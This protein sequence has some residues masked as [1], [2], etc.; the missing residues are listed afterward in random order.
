MSRLIKGSDI[1]QGSINANRMRP[2][3][4][5][6]ETAFPIVVK[7][8][9]VTSATL[10]TLNGRYKWKPDHWDFDFIEKIE[11]ELEYSSDG[12][13]EITLYDDSSSAQLKS[14]VTLS[15][16][17]SYTIERCDVTSEIQAL[18]SVTN[19]AIQ[20]KGDGTNATTVYKATLVV[21][22]KL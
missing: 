16:A 13:G 2:S 10:T 4:V 9:A 14:L 3:E 12:A 1:V 6:A 15:G 22:I 17:T 21:T 20:A 7:D 19:L 18:S 5:F 11:V 8:Q